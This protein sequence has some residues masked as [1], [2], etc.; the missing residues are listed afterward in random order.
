MDKMRVMDLLAELCGVSTKEN[1]TVVEIRVKKDG[2]LV[3]MNQYDCIAIAGSMVLTDENG[4]TRTASFVTG[5]FDEF[6]GSRLMDGLDKIQYDVAI[7]TIKSIS[8]NGMAPDLIRDL[9]KKTLDEVGDK[10]DKK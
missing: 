9:C 10:G 5:E 4:K 7:A 6:I 1:N 3:V 8:N 2:E